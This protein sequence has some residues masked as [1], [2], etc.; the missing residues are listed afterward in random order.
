MTAVDEVDD[1]LLNILNSGN[2]DRF[3]RDI[4]FSRIERG[5]ISPELLSL[6]VDED[7]SELDGED[8]IFGSLSS[9]AKDRLE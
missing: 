9:K 7:S 3:V 2:R 4:A 6:L 1:E 5:T 8:K